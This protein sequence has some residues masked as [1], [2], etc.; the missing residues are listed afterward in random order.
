MLFT[1]L[2]KK[3]YWVNACLASLCIL[4]TFPF[5]F[6]Q[7]G[8]G[9]VGNSSSNV[10]W[11]QADDITG[12]ND[13]DNISNWA[14]GSGNLNDVSQ[15]NAALTPEYKTSILNG[16][17][18]VRFNKNNGRIRKTNFTTFPTTAITEF[19]VNSSN[20]SNDGMLSYASTVNNNDF[21]LFSSNSLRIYRAGNTN[22]G[23]SYNGNIWNIGSALWRNSDGRSEVWKNGL[24]AFNTTGFQTGTSITSGGCLAIAGEQDA[25]DANY[26]ANQAH[27]GDFAEV[28]IYNFFL[29]TA[30]NI[31]V[32]NYLAAKYNIAISNDHFSFQNSHPHDV[33]G[34][35]REDAANLHT[36]AMSDN[37]LQIQNASDLNIDQEYLLFGHDAAN[38][39]VWTTAE[40]PNG[41]IDIQRLA[42]EWRMNE[43][44]DVGTVDFVIDF[45][46]LPVL[47]AGHGMY[48]LMIDSD[49]DFSNGASVYEMTLLAGTQ[50]TVSGIDI[51][52]GDFVAIAAVNPTIQ[53]S[54]LASGDFEPNNAVI[55]VAL[56]FIPRTNKSVDFTASDGTATSAQPDFSTTNGT[57]TIPAGSSTANY[58]IAITNDVV[59]EASETFTLSLSNPSAGINLGANTVHTYTIQDEDNL[60]KVFFDLSASNADESV[61]LVNISVSINNIDPINPTTVEYNI[62]G[63]T[64][65][66]SGVDYTVGS[67]IL[68]FPPGSNNQNFSFTVNDDLIY[69]TSETIIFNLNN[70]T[71]CNIDGFAPFGGTGIITHTYTINDNDVLPQIQFSTVASSGSESLSPVSFEV[72]L[73]APTGVD[74]TANYTLSGTATGGGTDYT[75]ANGT[76]TIAGGTTVSNIVAAITDDAVEELPE[77]IVLTLSAPVNAS[78]GTNMVTTYTISDNDLFGHLGPG[79][80]GKASNN[81]LWVKSGDLPV[82]ANGTNISLWT[83]ASG[84]AHDLTQTTAGFCPRYY[85]NVL[86]SKPVVRFEQSNGRL[87]HNGFTDFPSRQITAILVNR[88]NESNDA[89]LSYAIP[90]NNNEYLWFNSSSLNIYRGPNTN[91]GTPVNGNTFRILGNTWQGSSGDTRFYSNGN[92]TSVSTLTSGTAISGGGCLAIAGEQDAVNGGYDPAQAHFGDFSEVLLYNVILNSAQR[93][94]VNNY[95]SSKYNIPVANDL[96][97]F[98]VFGTYENEVAGIGRDDIN[99]FHIDAQGTAEV[100]INTPSGMDD[101]EF[102]LWGH[103]NNNI[104]IPNTFDVPTTLIAN[105]SEKIWRVDE[106]GDVGTVTVDVDITN[107]PMGLDSDLVLLIDS[108]DGSFVNAAIVS[109]SSFAGNIATFNNVS[110]SAG[111]W[112]TIANRIPGSLPIDLISFDAVA[113]DFTVDLNWQTASQTNNDYFTVERSADGI[114]WE[115]V[116]EV[117]GEGTLLNMMNYSAVDFNPYPGTSYYQLR[118]TDFNGSFSFSDI[119]SVFIEKKKE[120]VLIYPNPF[121]NQI[122]I[123]CSLKEREN[124][125]LF[126]LIGQEIMLKESFIINYTQHSIVDLSE[127]LPG[128]YV[129]RTKNTATKVE[130]R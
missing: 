82:T 25:V 99:N 62:S 102:M 93:K 59:V 86:N 63:G 19:F 88:N 64:A 32:S 111:N 2:V 125:Q 114:N 23:I 18:V 106:T 38:S 78:P 4:F 52:D 49:G 98:D 34:I 16:L 53:H 48:A 41:G 13:G 51:N 74:V 55:E 92:L 129:L 73:N 11:L 28:I 108:D 47:P 109:I 21:L 43:T 115:A 112:F 97:A 77:T 33:A 3:S 9:G 66:A 67:G 37:I 6:A 7:T 70:P 29:N 69:E 71:N 103:D 39:N 100:R 26:D 127:L 54:L 10:L 40:A 123:Q 119:Q 87:I 91:T 81:K 85:N 60:R 75:L 57:L 27:F 31:I 130:K 61:S 72:E 5:L 96:Y 105:R 107:F 118:Q 15:P 68:T 24:Q 46:S 36:A 84:N 50:Y 89:L 83:D 76:V 65:L 56:N 80:V 128:I 120:Q 20:E 30:Q 35:G 116:T 94:I 42:R 124:I 14:D 126:S 12:L 8:P 101:G 95:L 90:S 22:S 117:D 45:A 1:P 17:P 113:K 58:F 110:F 122:T 44:G 104:T 79:G 121:I